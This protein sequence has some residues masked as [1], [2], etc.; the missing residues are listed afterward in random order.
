MKDQKLE[1]VSNF[2]YLGATVT[3]EGSK[4]EVLTRI[5]ITFK[6][7]VRNE[8]VRSQVAAAIG[9]HD[10]LLT[11]VKTRKMRWYSHVTRS[12]GLAKTIMQGTVPGGRKRGRPKKRW[13]D[14]I[15]E[16]TGLPLAVTLRLA[17][18]RTRWREV[19]RSSA[20]PQ[21]PAT[22]MGQR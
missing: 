2:K 16:W 5:G 20:V 18:D 9:R 6:D 14:N 7:R 10:D 17:E 13:D 12:A 21:Q 8:E 15:R 19:V 22:A 1:S 4:R 11:I 3:D